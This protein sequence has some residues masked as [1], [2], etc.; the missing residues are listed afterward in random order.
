MVGN[1]YTANGRFYK[2]GVFRISRFQ[3]VFL[4]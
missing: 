1:S 4:R 3:T 2:T